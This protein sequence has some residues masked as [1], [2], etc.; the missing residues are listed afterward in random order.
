MIYL[1]HFMPLKNS[2]S[3]VKFVLQE[4][5]ATKSSLAFFNK[6]LKYPLTS[7]RLSES[8]EKIFQPK[9]DRGETL[10][11]AEEPNYAVCVLAK[12]FGYYPE[13]QLTKANSVVATHQ[14]L[15]MI[16][17]GKST[18]IKVKLIQFQI[19][20]SLAKIYANEHKNPRTDRLLKIGNTRTWRA[21]MADIRNTAY[22]Q[23]VNPK[24]YPQHAQTHHYLP[25]LQDALKL[26]LF[27]EH[28]NNYSPF[29]FRNKTHTVKKI[30][31]TI[32]SLQR[33]PREVVIR[34]TT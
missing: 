18:D 2:I 17:G 1:Q 25:V 21:L 20:F 9:F 33:P 14:L 28:R 24:N 12:F 15:S 10:S 32:A 4:L 7:Q 13:V 34:L 19:L 8:I 3:A 29:F 22:A 30:Q 23:L 5:T 31:A 26:P 27:N 16:A 11:V 6:Q